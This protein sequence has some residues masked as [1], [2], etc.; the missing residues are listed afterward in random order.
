MTKSAP[1]PKTV[2]EYVLEWSL[3]RPLWQRD[4]LRRIITKGSLDASDLQELVELCKQGKMGAIDGSKP[5]PLEKNHLPANP[6]AGASAALIAIKDVEGV[7]NLAPSQTL[8]FEPN[9]LTVI[10]GDNGAGKSGYSRI[11]K[12]ACRARHTEVIQ[13]NIYAQASQPVASATIAYSIGGREQPEEKWQDAGNPHP[14]FSAI[15][16]FDSNCASVHIDGKNEVA[17]RPFGLDVPD[18]LAGVCQRVKDALTA[19]QKQLEKARNPVFAKPTWKEDTVVGKTLSSLTH[20]VDTQR[21]AAL[22]TLSEEERTRLGRLKEDL[23]KNPA[24]AAAEQ[25]LEADNIKALRNAVSLIAEQT[26]DE[27]LTHV[28][29]LARNAKS[30]R[31]AARLAAEEAFSGEPLTGVGGDAWRVLWDA[32]RRYSTQVAYPGQ[33]FPPSEEDAL[34]ALCQQP[35]EQEARERM[36]QFEEFIKKDTERLAQKAEEAFKVALRTFSSQKIDIRPLKLGRQKIA[37]QKPALARQVLHFVAAARLRRYALMKAL[38]GTQN[39]H[40][41]DMVASPTA[42]LEQIENTIRQYALELQRSATGD[43]RKRLEKSFAELSDRAILHDILPIVHE[44]VDRLKTIHFL[45][46]CLSDTTTTAITRLGNEIADTVITPRLRDRFQEEIVKLAAEKVRVEIARS[47]GKFGSPHYQ[48]RLFAKPDAKVGVILSEGEKTCVALAA[49]LTELATASHRSALVFDDPVSS[50]DHRWR[51]Q[52]AKRLVEE[53]DNRQVIVFT[54]DLVFVN[55]LHTLSQ[56]KSWPIKF[57]TINRGR[58]GA[59]IVSDG[60]PWQAQ[61]VEDRIDKLEKTA[62]TAKQLYENNQDEEY[63]QKAAHI[64]DN[65]RASWERALED[66]AFSSVIQRHR[67]Y[68]NT[69]HLKKASV[70]S[71]TDCE[72]F[73]AGFKKCC[74]IVDAHDPSRARNAEAPPPTEILQDIQALKDWVLSL[75]S[76]QKGIN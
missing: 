32:A 61:K 71:A 24:K 3:Q 69:K 51:N 46:Q 4:A 2:L 72:V 33:P 41:P 29:T 5:V 47:G 43:E 38:D 68:I 14:V 39:L 22:A 65:L 36:A 64:Y 17:F 26:T 75:R 56:G 42:E 21:I 20:N 50:L 11:L 19:E 12:R 15:S 37:I 27:A 44:E 45:E 1:S 7:N 73:E 25:R 67:D 13:S 18:E 40:L 53:A 59:G 62:R 55:D 23:S 52:V 30:K 8:A 16:V 9:C 76:R 34:C 66:I 28:F 48:I 54:H 6:G 49:F 63:R 74:G 60:L 70:L 57:L 58:Q 10:Y 35:L 31:E